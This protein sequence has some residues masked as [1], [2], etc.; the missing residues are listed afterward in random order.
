MN[1]AAD[2][3]QRLAEQVA[4]AMLARDGATRALGMQLQAVGPGYACLR[5][6]VRRDM[7]NGHN[8]CHGGLIFSLADSAFAFACNSRNDSTVA[9]GC[10]IEFLLP[11]HEGDV[12]QAE[13]V[14]KALSGKS[15]IYDVSVVNQH[16]QL[17]AVFRGKSHRIRGTVLPAAADCTEQQSVCT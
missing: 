10:Q 9:A 12:L 5:M 4:Q 11:G 1:E 7:L 16:G 6:S 13:A 17:I 8:T 14:E 15:G 2:L 3:A